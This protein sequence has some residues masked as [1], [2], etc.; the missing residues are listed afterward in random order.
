M[1]MFGV[2]EWNRFN[3]IRSQQVHCDKCGALR[4]PE[5]LHSIVARVPEQGVREVSVCTKC[6]LSGD[7]QRMV[8]SQ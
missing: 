7:I 2:L 1:A 5:N 4:L 8:V 3:L 6:L